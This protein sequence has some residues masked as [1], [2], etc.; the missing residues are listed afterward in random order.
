LHSEHIKRGGLGLCS[1]LCSSSSL[2]VWLV[3]RV[4]WTAFPNLEGSELIML[5]WQ[6]TGGSLQESKEALELADTDGTHLIQPSP[7]F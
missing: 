2:N 5:S 7:A 4:H 1:F 6:V 3:C